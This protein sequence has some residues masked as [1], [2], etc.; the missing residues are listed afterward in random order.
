MNNED[1]IGTDKHVHNECVDRMWYLRPMAG[2]WNGTISA[3]TWQPFVSQHWGEWGWRCYMFKRLIAAV[4]IPALKKKWGLGT[5]GHWSASAQDPCKICPQFQL[6]FW[7][8]CQ[9]MD[10]FSTFLCKCSLIATLGSQTKTILFGDS[11]CLSHNPKPQL[12][13]DQQWSP[14]QRN[15]WRGVFTLPATSQWLP[16]PNEFVSPILQL[17]SIMTWSDTPRVW[18]TN[19][20]LCLTCP[21]PCPSAKHWKLMPCPSL[22]VGPWVEKSCLLCLSHTRLGEGLV[23]GKV[24][25]F[26][27]KMSEMKR[28]SGCLWY[29]QFIAFWWFSLSINT[30]TYFE[31]PTQPWTES[32]GCC[33]KTCRFNQQ[34]LEILRDIYNYIIKSIQPFCFPFFVFS[35]LGFSGRFAV[36]SS[37]GGPRATALAGGEDWFNHQ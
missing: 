19:P 13:W 20:E 11:S 32:G 8:L 25:Q 24:S 17:K 37:A 15:I 23:Y 34:D 26:Q 14:G 9:F 5:A 4:G 22:C 33:E 12:H 35:S 1:D 6:K 27:L 2:R 36:C 18:A 10:K 16:V 7:I 28:V 29:L 30:L 3:I 21:A 31:V